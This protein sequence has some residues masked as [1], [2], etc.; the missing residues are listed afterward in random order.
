MSV[1]QLKAFK[2][3]ER[4]NADLKAQFEAQKQKENTDRAV[5]ELMKQGDELKK[6]YPGFDLANELN[7]PQFFSLINNNIDVRTAYE[8]IHKDEIIPAAMQ[9]AVSSTK[10]KIANNI[11]AGGSSRPEENGL[12]AAS[13]VISTSDVSQLTKA[14]REELIKRA[15][16]GERITFGRR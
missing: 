13:S 8:V 16:A 5:A 14:Q 9:F 15:A 1:E 10:Q 7:N 2:K 12:S 4:E 3:M 11:M 6:V